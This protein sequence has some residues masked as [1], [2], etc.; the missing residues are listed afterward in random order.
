[1][2]KTISITIIFAFFIFSCSKKNTRILNDTIL[3]IRI[4]VKELQQI[5]LSEIISECKAIKLEFTDKSMIGSIRKVIFYNNKIYVL[6]TFGAKSLMVFD[7]DGNF[8]QRIGSVGN[9]PGQFS[10]PQDFLID[11][12]RNEIEILGARKINC[13]NEN[14]DFLRSKTI[15][16]TSL[17]FM[18]SGTNYF[19]AVAGKEDYKV[20]KT[21]LNGK[22]VEKYLSTNKD[23]EI[24]NA[25]MCFIPQKED[26]LLFRPT[27]RDTIYFLNDKTAVPARV[28]DFGNYKFK[29]DEFR[30]LSFEEQMVFNTKKGNIN[31]CLIN[32][33]FENSNYI[34][35]RYDM[36]GNLYEYILNKKNGK[37]IH[38]GKESLTDDITWEKDSRWLLG[39]NDEYIYHIVEPHKYKSTKQLRKF[40]EDF[41]R[42]GEDN[43]D[44]LHENLNPILLL[45]KY[46]I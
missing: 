30:K 31:Q 11:T 41:S 8:K 45:T 13:Y 42:K 27:K 7:S 39:G 40:L 28:I 5:K 43:I 16:F 33:Y 19:F 20:F 6:D 17:N 4:P 37:Y 44:M 23:Y 35:I 25:F 15:K 26:Y 3:N 46:K 32:N 1:M 9:G 2:R 36:S 29:L 14:G 24:G 38:F 22:V 21:D 18:K 12:I 34:Q 10:M